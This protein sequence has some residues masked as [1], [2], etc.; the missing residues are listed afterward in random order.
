MMKK[1][2]VRLMVGSDF[3]FAFNNMTLDQ[4]KE[5]LKG[6]QITPRYHVTDALLRSKDIV[7]TAKDGQRVY[8]GFSGNNEF[9]KW[10]NYLFHVNTQRGNTTV[11]C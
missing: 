7:S 4:V 8:R 10:N 6:S 5:S 9:E 2:F 11:F 3:I 1:D